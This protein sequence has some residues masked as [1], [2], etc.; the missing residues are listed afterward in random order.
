[1]THMTQPL[2]HD[3]R[4]TETADDRRARLATTASAVNAAHDGHLHRS[5]AS[6]GWER[7]GIFQRLVKTQ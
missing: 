6:V 5:L 1:M 7:R 3:P 2:V 4:P